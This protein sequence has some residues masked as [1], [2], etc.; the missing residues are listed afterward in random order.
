LVFGELVSFALNA[1]FER[2]D[3]T[4]ENS[5]KNCW[6]YPLKFSPDPVEDVFCRVQFK[7]LHFLFQVFGHE[8]VR[9]SEVR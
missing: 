4:L 5:L 6:R 7:A 2:I 3:P 1:F 8:N 9:W